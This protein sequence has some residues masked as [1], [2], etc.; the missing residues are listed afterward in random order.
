MKNVILMIIGILLTTA[1]FADE[2]FDLKCTLDDGVQMTVSHGSHTVYIAFFAPG[3][4]PDEGGGLIKLDIPS[5]EVK[6]DILYK[7][8]KILFFGLR[9]DSPESENAVVVSFYRDMKTF[10]GNK[11]TKRIYTNEMSF[12]RQNKMTGE[13][14]E[15]KCLPDTIRIGHS[16]TEKG[17]PNVAYI[18]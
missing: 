8:G 15:D 5:G 11:G 16:L 3:D 17:I 12:S 4:D 9:G 1:S 2:D 13:N 18:Q 14:I 7:D 6:Q 10:I